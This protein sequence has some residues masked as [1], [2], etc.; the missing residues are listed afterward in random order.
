MSE[1]E[2]T[3]P[4]QLPIALLDAHPDNSNVMPG[5][6]LDKLA[7]QIGET[8][9]YPPVIV[10]PVGD[11]YQI[12]DGHHRVLVLRRLGHDSAQCVVW[13]VDDEQAL[14]LLATLN[15]LAGDDDPRKRAALV[16]KLGRSMDTKR[17]ADR[18]PED[19]ER[20]RKLLSIHAAPPS[21]VKPRPIDGMPVCLHFFLLPDQRRAVE[22]VLREQGGP[23]EQALLELLGLAQGACD[24][25]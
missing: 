18:L 6:L 8:G 21:P 5:A 17:L 2:T 4:A 25:G 20:V 12:L 13:P 10:R 24:G 19:A 1:H 9:R 14:L 11:R 16:A 22:R 7:R 15:R 3:A 23:R